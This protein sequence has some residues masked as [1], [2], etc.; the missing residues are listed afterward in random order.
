MNPL[1][2]LARPEIVALKPYSHAAW[3]PS[4]IRLHAN[5]APWRPPGD[6]TAAGLNRYPEPQPQELIARLAALYQVPADSVL[7]TRGADEAIDV[8]SRI[9]LRAGKDAILQVSPT[10]GM[11]QVSARIQGAEVIDVPL[12]RE[13]GWALDPDELLSAWQPAIK[14]V[15][16]C[17]PNNPTANLF[18]AAAMMRVCAA[19]DGKAIVVIDEAYIEWSRS[20]SLTRWLARF[21][22]LAVLRTLSKAHA[23]AGARVGALIAHPDMIK[24]AK[25]VI[26]PYALAQPTV[27][28]ALR[29]LTPDELK[30]S[31]QRLDALLEERHR[32]QHA[33][34]RSPLVER[35]HPSDANFLLV[36]CRDAEQFMRD[37][38]TAG[39]IVRD[40]RGYTSLPNFLRVSIGTAAENDALLRS[41]GAA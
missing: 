17:S 36:E 1:V 5:E 25:K 27:E 32:V 23:L 12:R 11:Y 24:L 30:R 8:L 22:T 3:L 40:L 2:S 37:S 35:V 34:Q 4:L 14:L 28:A 26:P 6:G 7:A 10:F 38:M 16:L 31:A 18:D 15:Y 19:L 41:V 21:Q 9:Y 33:L 20:A 13:H 39:Y 29:A